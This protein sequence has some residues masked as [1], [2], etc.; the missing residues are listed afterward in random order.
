MTFHAVIWSHQQN[1]KVRISFVV[2]Y[3]RFLLWISFWKFF[4]F[5]SKNFIEVI[6]SYLHLHLQ[7]W[8]TK[9]YFHNHTLEIGQVVMLRRSMRGWIHFEWIFRKIRDKVR[10]A[11]EILKQINSYKNDF[12]NSN[13]IIE[14]LCQG[15]KFPKNFNFCVSIFHLL[16][17]KNISGRIF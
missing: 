16:A 2:K 10:E 8:V 14:K 7:K 17:R 12:K 15:S 4:I 1:Q 13:A 6:M 9:N 3:S 11:E 5:S